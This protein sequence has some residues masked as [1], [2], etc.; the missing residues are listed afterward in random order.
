MSLELAAELYL[1]L[2]IMLLAAGVLTYIYLYV[3]VYECMCIHA[4]TQV[5]TVL[6]D[7]WDTKAMRA[8]RLRL[9]GKI[10]A[11][12]PTRTVPGSSWI[13]HYHGFSE[14]GSSIGTQRIMYM[15]QHIEGWEMPLLEWVFSHI[16]FIF[17]S[18]RLTKFQTGTSTDR[19]FLLFSSWM[20]YILLVLQLQMLLI[21]MVIV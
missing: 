9:A 10:A 2:L 15:Q 8:Q 3:F 21:W 17:Q 16:L 6:T 13:L 20:T 1:L 11:Q 4:N 5:M 19:V 14:A 18:H 12:V 7:S